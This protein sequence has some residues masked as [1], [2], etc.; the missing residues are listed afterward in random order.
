MAQ[1]RKTPVTPAPKTARYIKEL[2]GEGLARPSGLNAQQVRELAAS[3]MAHIEPRVNTKTLI[4]EPTPKRKSRGSVLYD[5][6]R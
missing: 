3:V 5:R 1:N 6:K 2:A 4:C